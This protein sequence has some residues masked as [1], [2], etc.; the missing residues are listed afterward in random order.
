[1]FQVCGIWVT[2]LADAPCHNISHIS[3]CNDSVELD[4]KTFLA[5]W[6]VARVIPLT[7]HHRKL[8]DKRVV[9]ETHF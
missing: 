9:V 2:I 6:I 4:E 7:G 3:D 5:T 8:F 1:M